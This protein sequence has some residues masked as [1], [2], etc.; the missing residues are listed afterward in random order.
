MLKNTFCHICL[1]VNRRTINVYDTDARHVYEKLANYKMGPE[2]C[3]VCYVCHTRLQQ[4]VSLQKTASSSQSQPLVHLT[5]HNIENESIPYH[6]VLAKEE[7]QE[8]DVQER[9]FDYD[10][11]IKREKDNTE[12]L[13]Y[14]ENNGSHFEEPKSCSISKRTRREKATEQTKTPKDALCSI[15]GKTFVNK[16]SL[17]TH[18]RTH[19]GEKPYTCNICQ[20]K[21]NTSGYLIKH[22]RI[23]TGEKPYACETCG[24]RYRQKGGLIIHKRKHTGEKLYECQICSRRFYDSSALA[25]HKRS[26]SDVRPYACDVCDKKFLRSYTLNEHKR[27][28]KKK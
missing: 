24:V 11:T 27:I 5:T 26:H 23:H 14:E 2:L 15:C 25:K 19:T 6:V 9:Y 28:H 21:F 13:D 7:P 12:S 18:E 17:A 10:V 1:S 20:K 22:M 8:F 16:F 4:F 3:C